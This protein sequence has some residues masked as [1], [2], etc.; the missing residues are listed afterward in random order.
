M[1]SWNTFGLTF[2]RYSREAKVPKVRLHDLRHSLASLLLAGGADLK[3]VSTALGHSTIAM[4]ADTYAHIS[5]AMLHEAANLMDTLWWR[6]CVKRAENRRALGD[7]CSELI[8]RVCDPS[9]S[10]TKVWSAKTV[11]NL[12]A[13]YVGVR[14]TTDCYCESP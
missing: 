7:D 10:L 8:A 3:T 12:S 1:E 11:T 6:P 14:L 2:A 5:P 9:S 4:T 13:R